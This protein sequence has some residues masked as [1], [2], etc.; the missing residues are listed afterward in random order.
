VGDVLGET[1][2][3]IGE[4]TGETMHG[5]QVMVVQKARQIRF[6]ETLAGGLNLKMKAVTYTQQNKLETIV[7]GLAVGCRHISEMQTKLVPDT[8]AAE[9][10]GM[11][12]F[13]D[14]SQINAFL[15][16]CG[17][18]QVAH[19][20][21]AQQALLAA[22]SLAG[23]RSRW[24]TLADGGRVLT[25]DLDQ[26]PIATRSKRATGTAKGYFGRKR[27]N[28][29]YKKSVALLGN[30]VKEV[31]WLGLE[32]GNAHGQDAVPTVLA[33]LAALAKAQ[34][35]APQEIMGRGDSQYGSVGVIRQFQAA[36]MHYLF[37]GYAPKTAKQLAEELPETAIWHY[38]GADSNGS[39]VWVTDAGEQELRGHDDPAGLAPVQTRVVLQVR[40]AWRL[41]KKHGRGA[42]NQVPEKVVTYEHYVTD[43]PAEALPLV[44]GERLTVVDVY[45]D[46]ETEESFFRSE[47]DALGAHCLR[48]YKR[49]G[50]AA[51]LWLLAS[52]VNL[53]RWTQCGVFA[54]TKLEGAG[55]TKL[56]TQVMQIPASIIRTTQA[57]VITLPETLRL[58]RHLVNVWMQREIQLPL[59]LEF[60]TNT[61]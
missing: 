43:L 59:P 33:R 28:V 41:H 18:E 14:Q 2:L 15:R 53:L 16:A 3:E 57:M 45:N 40:V 27:G 9:L 11:A 54:G 6:F 10:F 56:V 39:Q 13:P 44:A 46:R 38:R 23:D 49:E 61:S 5:L 24:F 26:T 37:K 1:R 8:V 60:A 32:P 20:S 51:F 58:A 31:L 29:G 34:G 25:V 21:Q 4:R 52:T 47:Q 55:L 35:I 17:P 48:T 19:L 22:N 42:P 36:G 30:G 7:A 12:R 50:E